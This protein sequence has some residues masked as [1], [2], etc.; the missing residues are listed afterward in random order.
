MAVDM[1][2]TGLLEAGYS[3][4]V[5]AAFFTTLCSIVAAR[6]KSMKATPAQI[7]I[8]PWQ[9]DGEEEGCSMSKEDIRF[10]EQA[11]GAVLSIEVCGGGT[12]IFPLTLREDGEANVDLSACSS[13]VFAD[14]RDVEFQADEGKAEDEQIQLADAFLV[15]EAIQIVYLM[16]DDTVF[17]LPLLK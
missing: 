12:V 7:S 1:L 4:V 14:N 16:P 6:R 2:G 17:A 5:A 3:F 11:D 15:A 10:L 9:F 8:V 13:A